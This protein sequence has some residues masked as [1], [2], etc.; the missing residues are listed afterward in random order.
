MLFLSLKQPHGIHNRVD[1]YE[2]RLDTFSE[3]DK[4]KIQELCLNLAPVIF[5]L[6]S[7]THG[8]SFQGTEKNRLTILEDLLSLK[9]DYIDLECDTDPSFIEKVSKTYPDTKI[10]LSYHNF[11]ETPLDLDALLATMVSSFAYGY[12]IATLANSSLDA[13][14][15]LLFVK[16]HKEYKISGICMG[17]EGEITR[18]LGPV[19]GNFIDFV[20]ADEHTRTA[21]GQLSVSDLFFIYRYPSLNPFTKV[22]ALI[23]GNI[24]TSIS[25]HTH[26]AVMHRYGI[27]A[28]YIKMNVKKE[29]LSKFLTLSKKCGIVGI[30]VTSPLKEEVF[31]YVD[32]IDPEFKKVGALNTLLLKDHK[33][34]GY[35][36]DGKGALLA[37]EKKTH[38]KGKK[39]VLIGAGGAARAI[40]YALHQKGAN[41]TVLNR[42][43]QKALTIAQELVCKYGSLEDLPKESYEI[44][45]DATSHPLS[46]Y[47]STWIPGTIVMD[48]KAPSPMI[49]SLLRT[50]EENGCI[51]VYAYEMFALQAVEQF[52][53][54]LQQKIDPFFLDNECLK[55]VDQQ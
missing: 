42:T 49:T 19:F 14:R 8:G 31:K 12:K 28:V 30:S 41:L 20:P 24:D 32:E 37:L 21:P 53:I 35:N 2:L 39:V 25:H 55:W 11:Q 26:N 9:P 43:E 5:T 27:N 29:E 10:I 51:P 4:E 17:K 22:Y 33:Y 45:I 3:I 46:I 54:W 18:I 34:I 47:P 23:S 13:L 36:T 16:S 44:L 7:K 48:V 52:W 50:A 1:G 15:M 6:R 40:A 38:L